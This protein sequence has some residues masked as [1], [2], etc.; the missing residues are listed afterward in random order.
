MIDD[1]LGDIGTTHPM[2]RLV[3]GDVGSGKTVVAAAAM[4]LAAQSRRAGGHHGP[5]RDSGRTA[6]QESEQVI[7]D[8][9]N[10]QGIPHPLNVRLLTG[11]TPQAERETILAEIAD[12]RANIIVGTHALI[13]ET[14]IVQRSGAGHHRRAASLWRGAARRLRQKGR[15]SPHV[16]VMTA[17]PIP[18]T[19]AL[20]LYGDLDLSV[21][22]QMPPGR[23]PIETRIVLPTERERAYSFIR[24]QIEK[25]RQAF[26][27]CPLVEESDKIEAKAAV[28]EHARLQKHVF[29]QFNWA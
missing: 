17:T 7:C 4:F 23:Q 3:Q 28:E 20:T 9:V 6:L 29:P 13:Q 24:A 26:I 11:S 1:I 22:D 27:I 14:V 16:L 10:A 5:D 19:L 25:G 15:V 2:S 18:R 12:G 8:S 21:I